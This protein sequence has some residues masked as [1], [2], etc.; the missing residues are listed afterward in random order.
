MHCSTIHH[1]T[2]A[3]HRQ[4]KEYFFNRKARKAFRKEH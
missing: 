2:K 4:M 1:A 3:A